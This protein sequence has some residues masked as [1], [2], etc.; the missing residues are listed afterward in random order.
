MQ[1]VSKITR[2][3]P[4]V[5]WEQAIK[6]QQ[7]D[8]I[9]RGVHIE[10]ASWYLMSFSAGCFLGITSSWS[11]DTWRTQ[12]RLQCSRTVCLW[13][14]R[15]H[16]ARDTSG[17]H[18]HHAAALMSVC[19]MVTWPCRPW[20]RQEQR[21]AASISRH[22]TVKRQMCWTSKYRS[23]FITSTAAWHFRL[24]GKVQI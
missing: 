3:T 8:H 10:T 5:Y 23:M 18:R 1:T 11:S 24:H 15:T 12:V 2:D 21:Q 7:N 16:A 17:P 20:W 6:W 22:F 19:H 4:N 9:C 14:T 13:T